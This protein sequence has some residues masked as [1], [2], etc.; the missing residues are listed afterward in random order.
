MPACFMRDRDRDRWIEKKGIC[1]IMH[2]ARRR[3]KR[4]ERKEGGKE[5][6]SEL[7]NQSV[8]NPSPSPNEEGVGGKK[9]KK[10]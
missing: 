6:L 8:Q 1:R 2:R 9:R 5:E 10:G 3:K 4:A 7:A